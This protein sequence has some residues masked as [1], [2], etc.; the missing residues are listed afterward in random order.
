MYKYIKEHLDEMKEG[1]ETTFTEFLE[2]LDI[3][4][5]DYLL[6]ILSIFER[7][8]V[9]LERN[10]SEIRVNPYMKQL[11]KAWQGNHDIQFVLDTYAYAMYI[12]SYIN[13]PQKGMSSLLERACK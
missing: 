10:P 8:R 3:S 11:I 5:N 6:A 12:V 13:K 4:E 2:D 1:R 7:S 9:L